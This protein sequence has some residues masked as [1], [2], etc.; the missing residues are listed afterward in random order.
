MHFL[1]LVPPEPRYLQSS[2][3]RRYLN[4]SSLE[5]LDHVVDFSLEGLLK[6]ISTLRAIFDVVLLVCFFL[7]SWYQISKGRKKAKRPGKFL[8]QQWQAV[9]PK[10]KLGRWK[11]IYCIFA[12]ILPYKPILSVV[13]VKISRMDGL[14]SWTKYYICDV[15]LNISTTWYLFCMQ[16]PFFRDPFLQTVWISK[17]NNLELRYHLKIC[18]ML[19]H[20][21]VKV[22]LKAM[23]CLAGEDGSGQPGPLKGWL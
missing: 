8:G 9:G 13:K 15:Y 5:H 16:I 3:F 19:C 17:V 14:Q 1:N 22:L 7:W 10:I 21:D 2:L 4:Y 6:S 12:H 20:W 18:N 11:Q 23:W